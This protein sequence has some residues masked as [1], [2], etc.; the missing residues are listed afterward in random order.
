[1]INKVKSYLLVDFYTPNVSF[2]SP[3]NISGKCLDAMVV[4][5]T[6]NEFKEQPPVYFLSS[7]KLTLEKE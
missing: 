7:Y 6:T 2:W 3:T 4:E 5:E 1:M